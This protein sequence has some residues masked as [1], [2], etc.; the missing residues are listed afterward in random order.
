MRYETLDDQLTRLRTQL[1]Q[2][3][4]E[5]IDAEADLADQKADIQTFALEY[6]ARIGV[7][8][9]QLATL[10]TEVQLYLNRI[11]A[12]RNQRVFGTDH[13]PVEEQFR[14]V[15]ETH[16]RVSAPRPRQP[17]TPANEGQLKKIYRQLARHFHPDLATNDADRVYRTEKM[18]AINDAYAA[19]SLAELV[20][21]SQE[22]ET[23]PI[24]WGWA[25]GRT[26]EDMV[27]VLAQELTR[28]QHR[29]RQIDL[30]RQSL[31]NHP[32][33]DLMLRVKLAQRQGND[34]LAEM[35]AELERKIARKTAERD[36]IQTQFDSLGDEGRIVR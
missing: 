29:L 36:M 22:I 24:A 28:C 8:L 16:D 9:A 7:L 26:K 6:N 32:H 1:A 3:Q 12:R 18:Q 11:Q 23:G 2:A 35:T 34:L 21:L 4:D 13:V 10:E 14:R 30:E 17:L 27:R 25:D 31:H 15:W 20:A 33:L 5:L 19:R